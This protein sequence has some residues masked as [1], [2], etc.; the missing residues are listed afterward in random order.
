[1][2]SLK[3]NLSYSFHV[4]TYLVDVDAVSKVPDSNLDF[5]ANRLASLVSRHVKERPSS[6]RDSKDEQSLIN[7]WVL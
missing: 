6:M 4:G 7:H 2:S 1:M 3:I 5:L